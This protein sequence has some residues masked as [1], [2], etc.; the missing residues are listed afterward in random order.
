MRSDLEQ[1]VNYAASQLEGIIGAKDTEAAKYHAGVYLRAA[2]HLILSDDI[3]KK[4]LGE[5]LV[6]GYGVAMKNY[7]QMRMI[8][9]RAWEAKYNS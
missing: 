4:R 1:W 6:D 5:E 3:H 7:F 8:Q 2:D 9:E